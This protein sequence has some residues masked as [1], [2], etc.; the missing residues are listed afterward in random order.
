MIPLSID[1]SRASLALVGRGE[2]ARRRLRG[3][4]AGGATRLRVF[5]DQADPTLERLAGGGWRPHLPGAA[6]LAGVQLVWVAGLPADEAASVVRQA[7]T[8]GVLVNVEDE[9]AACDFHNVAQV[10]RG[11]LLL[12]VSTGGKSPGLAARVRRALERQFGPEWAARLESLAAQRSAWKAEGRGAA[13]MAR[14]TAAKVDA[15]GWLG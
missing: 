2:V 12:T 11:D 4:L 10:R 13:A 15:E 6:D 8:A 1:P 14:L 5:S 7:R 3:L 9:P